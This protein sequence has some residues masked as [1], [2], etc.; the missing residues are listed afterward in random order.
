MNAGAKTC[1]RSITTRELS[2]LRLEYTTQLL[3]SEQTLK[4]K[5]GQKSCIVFQLFGS[6]A[7]YSLQILASH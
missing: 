1:S 5:Y 7:V 2:Y 6:D 3:K 4:H